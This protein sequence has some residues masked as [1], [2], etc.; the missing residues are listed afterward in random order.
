[1]R[2]DNLN[3]IRALWLIC[4]A[5]IFIFTNLSLPKGGYAGQSLFILAVPSFFLYLIFIGIEE[6]LRSKRKRVIKRF[7]IFKIDR[8]KLFPYIKEKTFWIPTYGGANPSN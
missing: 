5:I 1:M 8:K 3:K 6:L 4:I 7:V 2:D